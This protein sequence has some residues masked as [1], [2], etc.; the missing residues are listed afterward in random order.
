MSGVERNSRPAHRR[1]RRSVEPGAR[2]L[3]QPAPRNLDIACSALAIAI[4]QITE[5]QTVLPASHLT[6]CRLPLSPCAKRLTS[7]PAC[8][9]TPPPIT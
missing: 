8:W 9:N 4:A 7:S 5:L 3:L 1:R 6:I 2:L